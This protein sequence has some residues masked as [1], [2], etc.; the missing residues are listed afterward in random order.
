MNT[1]RVALDPE[2]LA[3]RIINFDEWSPHVIESLRRE[4]EHNPDEHLE[5]LLKELEQ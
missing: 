3:R 4:I 1:R 5:A 2:G